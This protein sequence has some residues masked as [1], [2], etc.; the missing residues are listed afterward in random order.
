MRCK[1]VHY[2]KG[3]SICASVGLI[4]FNLITKEIGSG[5]NGVGL[6][7]GMS[8]FRIWDGTPDFL[9]GIFSFFF[10]GG[11]FSAPC[12][13]QICTL[14]K[15]GPVPDCPQFI[16][17]QSTHH[18]TLLSPRHHHIKPTIH[19][20]LGI[21]SLKANPPS[22]KEIRAG[23]GCGSSNVGYIFHGKIETSSKVYAYCTVNYKIDF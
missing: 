6:F 16:S 1:N 18:W 4:W 13:K 23:H 12:H 8:L 5:G 19:K 9:W 7:W 10:W 20:G 15:P 2:N 3:S 21:F 11:G 17:H 14:M 22:H